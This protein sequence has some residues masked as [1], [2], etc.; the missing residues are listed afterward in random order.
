MMSEKVDSYVKQTVRYF[1]DDGLAELCIGVLFI[2]VGGVLYGWYTWEEN[3]VVNLLLS[4]GL[5]AAVLGGVFLVNK[6]IQNLKQRI[7]YDRTG[8]VAYRRD[9]KDKNRWFPLVLILGLITL[10]LFLPAAYSQMQF[11]VGGI[12][13]GVFIY[14]GYRID[15]WRFYLLGAAVMLIG[16]GATEATTNEILGTSLTFFSAGLLLLISGGITF[17]RYLHNHPQQE[18]DV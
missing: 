6:V 1:Y 18:E 13:A 9:E 3:G 12:M 4:A 10:T 7:T 14:M 2:I 5:I 15:L 8:Y 17:A 11:F 16:I